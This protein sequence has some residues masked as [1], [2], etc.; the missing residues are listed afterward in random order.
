VTTASSDL[1]DRPTVLVINIGTTIG[2]SVIELLEP[3]RDRIRLVATTREPLTPYNFRCDVTYLDASVGPQNGLERVA[4]VMRRERPSAVIPGADADVRLVAALR[5]RGE[6]DSVLFLSPKGRAAMIA[7]DKVE[8]SRFARRHG[9]PFAETAADLAE[10]EALASR[11]GLPL[12]VKPRRG[13]GSAGVWV[14]HS[15]EDVRA[16]MRLPQ[17]MAQEFLARPAGSID[18]PPAPTAVPLTVNAAWQAHISVQTVVTPEGEALGVFAGRQVFQRGWTTGIN[19]IRDAT[20]DATIRSWARA[21]APEGMMGPLN[22]EGHLIGGRF[23][24]FEINA[25][26]TDCSLERALVGYNDVAIAFEHFV[27]G[28]PQPRDRVP[29]LDHYVFRSLKGWRLARTDVERLRRDQ[30]WTA[31]E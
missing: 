5:Q 30:V 29:D 24:A 27:L 19:P 10:A 8:T 15:I 13:A 21:L 14:A 16:L 4:E 2:R 12:I 17:M 23:V 18:P 6:F 1:G 20:I 26:F 25:R 22:V 28:N 9:L 3:Y 7:T 31:A 11:R